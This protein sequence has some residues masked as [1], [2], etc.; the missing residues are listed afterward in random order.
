VTIGSNGV[1]VSESVSSSYTTVV[2]ELQVAGYREIVNSTNVNQF[3]AEYDFVNFSNSNYSTSS[4]KL[5]YVGIY[6]YTETEYAYFFDS[7]FYGKAMRYLYYNGGY[8]GLM[9]VEG[10]QNKRIAVYSNVIIYY[11]PVC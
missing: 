1:Q 2:N 11:T 10:T 3:K 7:I 8:H 4:S 9:P 5:I 6:K